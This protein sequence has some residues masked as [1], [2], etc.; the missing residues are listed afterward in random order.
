[1]KVLVVGDC[2]VVQGEIEECWNL[3]DFIIKTAKDNDVKSVLFLGD[4]FHTFSF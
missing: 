4:L 2:H 1:M 3:I